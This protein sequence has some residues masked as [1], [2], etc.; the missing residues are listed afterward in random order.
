VKI[1]GSSKGSYLRGEKEVITGNFFTAG[2]VMAPKK[3][4][5]K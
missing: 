1:K 4:G 5:Y 2:E 3:K